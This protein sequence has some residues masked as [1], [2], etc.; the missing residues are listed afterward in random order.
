M[1]SKCCGS[2]SSDT[3]SEV[4]TPCDAPIS[5]VPVAGC[6]PKNCCDNVQYATPQ[7][8]Y[9]TAPVC[10]EDHQKC[11]VNSSYVTSLKVANS[12]NVPDCDG[13]A[14]LTIKG[15]TNI[16]V[17]S[18]LW[19]PLYGYFQVI[20]FDASTGN[21]TIQNN[22]TAGNAT[23]GTQVP[24]CVNFIAAPPPVSSGGGGV[25][26]IYPYLAVDFTAPAL[27]VCIAVT[28][29]TTQG[30]SVGKNVQIGSG[31]YELSGITDS[32]TATICNRGAGAVAGTPVLARNSA[33]D[34]Q[35]PVILIDVNPCTNSAVTSGSL[36]VCNNAISQPLSGVLEG[37]VPFLIDAVN[38][39]VEFRAL[40]VPT[41]TCSSLAS[42]LTLV[43]GT[44]SY[45]IT[46]A[47]SS[48]FVVGDLLQIGTRTDRFTVTAINDS[49]HIT[50][51]VDVNPSAITDIEAGTSICIAD[52]CE[53]LQ[54]QIDDLPN[55]FWNDVYSAVAGMT[56]APFTINAGVPSASTPNATISMLNGSNRTARVIYTAQVRLNYQAI[57][58][59]TELCKYYLRL[60]RQVDGGGFVTVGDAFDTHYEINGDPQEHS[61]EINLTFVDIVA[62]G[63]TRDI[64]I[65]GLIDFTGG[66]GSTASINITG[67]VVDLKAIMIAVI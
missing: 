22:C 13:S 45:V 46:V 23:P 10:Q 15:L 34:L 20:S 53:L 32:T 27:N 16:L 4:N 33:G 1:G 38:N 19:N 12:W 64:D 42:C 60:Q 50:A 54:Q 31:V 49:T 39:T 63:D 56:P 29:T 8:Y 6:P 25:P 37:S 40:E 44:L 11:I 21:V 18:Y 30:L 3:V 2:K 7:P 17:G 9:T 65:R 57:N 55:E 67:M 14:I 58:A 26:T 62:P 48:Q 61:K 52:C 41:R 51:T 43:P 66:G 28:L 36:L 35:Y 5:Y 47:D 24:A 59:H